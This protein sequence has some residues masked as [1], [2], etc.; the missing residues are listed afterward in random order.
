MYKKRCATKSTQN[1]VKNQVKLQCIHC[2]RSFIYRNSLNKH[3]SKCKFQKIN[4]RLKLLHFEKT[5]QQ[6]GKFKH[7]FQFSCSGCQYVAKSLKNVFNHRAK[8]PVCKPS[9]S[10]KKK[11]SNYA[12]F[13]LNSSNTFAQ[14]NQCNH[15]YLSHRSLLK[16]KP[17]CRANKSK[18]VQKRYGYSCSI[19][20]RRFLL[21]SAC[22]RHVQMHHENPHLL[23]GGGK[24]RKLDPTSWGFSKS[25]VTVNSHNFNDAVLMKILLHEFRNEIDKR[26]SA[27]SYDKSQMIT[28]GVLFEC[29][30]IKLEHFDSNIDDENNQKIDVYFHGDPIRM[31]E[32]NLEDATADLIA[33][34]HDEI[35]EYQKLGSGMILSLIK[36]IHIKYYS[37]T[38]VVG[39]AISAN[40][41]NTSLLLPK[42]M[43]TCGKVLDLNYSN[44]YSDLSNQDQENV[45]EG[46]ANSCF[47]HC[48]ILHDYVNAKKLRE[49]TSSIDQ[50]GAK[51]ESYFH[52]DACDLLKYDESANVLKKYCLKQVSKP[53]NL[54]HINLFQKANLHINITILQLECRD[55][56]DEVNYAQEDLIELPS[57]KF[58]LTQ[59]YTSQNTSED[60]IHLLYWS[61]T[62]HF[63]Y[64]TN[65]RLLVLSCQTEYRNR[66]EMKLCRYC[67]TF[68]DDRYYSLSIHEELCRSKVRNQTTTLPREDQDSCWKFSNYALMNELG[69]FV[70]A[71]FECSVK[72]IY[73]VPFLNTVFDGKSKHFSEKLVTS[74]YEKMY[75]DHQF[76]LNSTEKNKPIQVHNLN[77]IGYN[78]HIPTDYQNF[79]HDEI[80]KLGGISGILTVDSDTEESQ[81]KLI[82]QFISLMNKFSLI[83]RNYM[84]QQN[85][86]QFQQKIVSHLQSTPDI[87]K[88]KAKVKECG[89]CKT[90]FINEKDKVL[91]HCH[92]SLKFRRFCHSK[93]NLKAKNVAFEDF[94]LPIY[95]HNLSSYDHAPLL[96]YAKPEM[97]NCRYSVFGETNPIWKCRTRGSKVVEIQCGA[98][99]FKDSYQLLPLKLEEVGRNLPHQARIYQR[100]IGK[101]SDG[102]GLYPYEFV[103][104]ISKFDVKDFPSIEEFTSSISGAIK[105]DEYDKSKAFFDKNCKTF[106]EYHDY[107]LNL[108]VA[109]LADALIYWRKLL[110]THFQV[111]LLKCASLPAAAKNCMLQLCRPRI[112]LIKDPVCYDIFTQNIRGGLTISAKRVADISDDCKNQQIKYFDIKSL[113]SYI[114]TLR[115]PIADIKL[116][117][118]TPSNESLSALAFNYNSDSDT[119]YTCVING[120]IP[121]HLHPL[122]SDFPIIQ[123]SRTVDKSFY[124]SDSEWSSRP[125]SRIKKLI[126]HL[127]EVENYG[128]TIDTLKFLLSMGFVLKKVVAVVSYTQKAFMKE[129]VEICQK[130]RRDGKIDGVVIDKAYDILWKLLCNAAFGKFIESPYNY[131]NSAFVFTRSRYEKFVQSLRFK[132]AS[133]QNYGALCRSRPKE[134][135]LNKP[136]MIGYSILCQS[137][138]HMMQLYYYRILPSYISCVDDPLDDKLQ[139]RLLYM[140]TDSMVLHFH[141]S[142]TQE[143]KFYHELKDIFDFSDIPKTDK[144]YSTHNA[145]KIGVFKDESKGRVI[146]KFYTTSAKCYWVE[147]KDGSKPMVK[148]KGV[149]HFVQNNQLSLDDFVN[150]FKHP[151]KRKNVEYYQIRVSQETRRIYT[152]KCQRKTLNTYDSKRYVIEKGYDSLAL[153]HAATR[154]L[155]NNEN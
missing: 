109:I 101:E 27:P 150:A 60:C 68:I 122:F 83:I 102:K 59:Y 13:E 67:L 124:P 41:S 14:C 7:K 3:V 129:F 56:E 142:P 130:L 11:Y 66:S 123:E 6:K 48:L 78:L 75:H 143:L 146:L 80:A 117:K 108:D 86:K 72:K 113:Y 65:L 35:D 155:T 46:V 51:I 96:R 90:P 82:H 98:I 85:N 24:M 43:Y 87:K 54:N 70:A 133:F 152:V 22:I 4:K 37:Y 134:I 154:R 94:T 93:C 26:K 91:D 28:A 73:P 153:G 5:V 144:L 50:Y 57:S 45:N 140:D 148:N 120:V 53:M 1:V 128:I 16:H 71:D 38:S 64:I 136:V 76:P 39:G 137:K 111:D 36:E 18:K 88:L 119:G 107:Y 99:E 17:S 42:F 103:D 118:P 61:K 10:R 58:V 145:K 47:E 21:E 40:N 12:K 69:T 97:A 31:V 44:C 84:E 100:K 49:K 132:S 77:T 81:E 9:N 23:R 114:E 151:E 79:P 104:S 25:T 34:V 147:Y 138:L 32:G 126:P 121:D 63:Y 141:L 127:F 89:Y 139:L 55:D 8:F 106:K 33:T 149:P 62:S 125:T 92:Y 74:A 29:I 30:F 19:C 52:V 116:I 95:F 105:Q 135:Y 15:F 115:H 2:E 131:E 20:P 110:M 112:S